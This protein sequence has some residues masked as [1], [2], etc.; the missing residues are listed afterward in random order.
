MDCST[1][2]FPVHHLRSLLKLMS[3][4]SVMPSN[5]LILCRPLL[6]PPSIFPWSSVQ[7]ILVTQSCPTLCCPMDYSLP[8]SSVHGIFQARVLEWV[9]ISFSKHNYE[10]N[11]IPVGGISDSGSHLLVWTSHCLLPT[12]VFPFTTSTPFPEVM[13]FSQHSPLLTLLQKYIFL[14][15]FAMQFAFYLCW[16]NNVS[17]ISQVHFFFFV[18]FTCD[19]IHVSMPFSHIIPP[20]PSPTEA[21]RLLYTSVSLL[22]SRMQGYRYHL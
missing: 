5:H 7:F 1:P 2:S 8:G 11:A 9:A 18:C 13:Q 4:E 22:L 10:A 16:F 12:P 6:F 15:P 20:S 17:F 19:I 21:K 3:I 14:L